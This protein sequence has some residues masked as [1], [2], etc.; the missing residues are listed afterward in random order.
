[1]MA[2]R[3]SQRRISSK[4]VR[5]VLVRVGSL[6]F[7][8]WFRRCHFE[9]FAKQRVRNLFRLS[10]GISRGIVNSPARNDRL[11]V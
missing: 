10:Y 2:A 8:M 4:M 7:L 11:F 6:V 3:R 1:M 9:R 5:V